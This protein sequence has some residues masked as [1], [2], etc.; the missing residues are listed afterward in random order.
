MAWGILLIHGINSS[1]MV[2]SDTWNMNVDLN[3]FRD[4]W[5]LT[6]RS[7]GTAPSIS[8]A[9]PMMLTAEGEPSFG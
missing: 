6:H 5:T 3:S 2:F 1:K 9:S 4:K 7:E 8:V